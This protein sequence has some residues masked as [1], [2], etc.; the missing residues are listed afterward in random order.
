MPSFAEIAIP[1][2]VEIYGHGMLSLFAS[3]GDCCKN[4]STTCIETQF[5][6]SGFLAMAMS[7]LHSGTFTT[8]YGNS[9]D[10]EEVLSKWG[11]YTFGGGPSP[12]DTHYINTTLWISGPMYTLTDVPI[13]LAVT[14]LL[15]Y[16]LFTLT[17]IVY[18]F[19]NNVSSTSWDSVSELTALAL[20]SE[21]PSS[22][23]NT[24]VGID[25]LQTYRHP[26][27]VKAK[28]GKWLQIVFQGDEDVNGPF[29]EVKSGVHY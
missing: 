9:S 10:K 13:K 11:Q 18:F 28:N 1:T 25:R 16:I 5:V 3:L 23:G 20:N 19:I 17:S 4:D 7:E 14:V 27:G 24:S 12:N 22:I 26:I 8:E 21:R 2:Q 6:L 15:I 29:E